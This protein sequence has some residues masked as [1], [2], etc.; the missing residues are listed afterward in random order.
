MPETSWGGARH[1]QGA[2][3]L[4]LFFVLGVLAPTGAIFWFMHEAARNQA[5]AAR[6]SVAEAYAGQ[7][8]L[9]RQ[10]VDDWLRTRAIAIGD[11]PGAGTTAEFPS[12]LHVS[13]A[14]SVILLDAHGGVIYPSL[15]AAPTPDPFM[16]NSAW[17][18]AAALEHQGAWD[19]AAADFSR[20]ADSAPNPSLY[21]R[22]AQSQVRC[23]VRGG[24]KAEAVET[25]LR[26]F[27]IQRAAQGTDLQGRVIAADEQL[28]ALQLMKRGDRRYPP[29]ADG[30]A[31]LLNDYDSV[32]MPSSQR[33]FL[34][35]E[36]AT[37][38]PDRAVFPSQTAERL[39]AQYLEGENPNPGGATVEA[40]GVR[41]LWKIASSNGRVLALY[42]T[43]SLVAAINRLLEEQSS[44]PGV[45][46]SVT[47]PGVP[48]SGEAIAAGP[49]LPGWLIAFS[50]VDTKAMESAAGSRLA[51]Y[52]WV[53]YL[54]IAALTFI[55][56]LLGH[57]FR[58]QF[59]LAQLKNDLVATVS[60]E[61]RTP[62]ASMR[63]LVES[64][65]DDK[66]LD[67]IKTR[68]YLDL[69]AG[70][71]R[72]LSRLVENF[73]T[74]S[75]IEHNREPFVFSPT[76]PRNV[77]ESAL[78]A[79]RERLPSPGCCLEVDVRPDLPLIYADGDALV[80]ALLNLLDNAFKYT[81]ADPR[82]SLRVYAEESWVVFC[83]EDNGIGITAREQKRIFRRF[84]RV[85]RRLAQ[86]TS[87][88]GLGLSIVDSIVRAH[89]G[90]V[91]ISSQRDSGSIFRILLP[92]HRKAGEARL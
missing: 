90:S 36:L 38:A 23:L 85:D 41:D 81:P 55:G 62:L 69:I 61:L 29:V 57:S 25:I 92:L 49:A 20:L 31:R 43:G 71:N 80:T 76:S 56:I 77:V 12:I 82:I 33:L 63:L 68:E 74:F 58:R 8:R 70:G 14:D 59:R 32:T 37:L 67:P 47:P 16:G 72:R 66:D 5:E 84:Y 13:G 3:L 28:L 21:A 89:G 44:S 91:S 10:R 19:A 40:T 24:H 78:L 75:R 87:G 60:H 18:I 48:P 53:G 27:S 52:L 22:A 9:L 15:L 45:R 7:L 30:L 83:V 64:L 65:Q 73:L 54:V 88:C 46:F 35:G 51:A 86:E 39:A 26:R 1:Y 11:Q 17:L 6:Q 34:M 4:L 2:W 50:L 79:M 42:R